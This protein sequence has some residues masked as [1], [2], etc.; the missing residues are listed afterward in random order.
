MRLNLLL[1][2]ERPVQRGMNLSL[3]GHAIRLWRIHGNQRSQRNAL[4]IERRV[5]QIIPGQLDLRPGLDGRIHR[6]RL[7]RRIRNMVRNVCLEL[8]ACDLLVLHRKHRNLQR[9]IHLR[10][11][12]R[13]LSIHMQRR[14]ACDLQ[15]SRTHGLQLAQIDPGRIQLRRVS[16]V[17]R[18]QRGASFHASRRKLHGQIAVHLGSCSGEGQLRRLHRLV[19]GRQVR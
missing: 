15:V 6:R 18:V 2:F 3:P 11:V 4:S 13:A 19:V 14:R 12:E 9:R 5:R 17:A 16:L 10:I 8:D 1:V 7:Q